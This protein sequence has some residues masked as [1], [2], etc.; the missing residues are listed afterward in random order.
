[1][2]NVKVDYIKIYNTNMSSLQ[3]DV[4]TNVKENSFK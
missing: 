4:L 1:M 3:E 2:E